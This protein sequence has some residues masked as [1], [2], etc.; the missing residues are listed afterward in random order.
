[1]KSFV[2]GN[3][4]PTEGVY[5]LDVPITPDDFSHIHQQLPS[6]M[7]EEIEAANFNHKHQQQ[8]QQQQ[9]PHNYSN[10]LVPLIVDT[11][12]NFTGFTSDDV[13][14]IG[15]E[16]N[17]YSNNLKDDRNP[18][19]VEQIQM[20]KFQKELD[21]ERR[22]SMKMTIDDRI[23]EYWPNSTMQFIGVGFF[24]IGLIIIILQSIAT[25]Y[26]IGLTY[27][28]AAGIWTGVFCITTSV[29]IL[30]TGYFRSHQTI[31]TLLLWVYCAGFLVF[32][33][34]FILS[35]L[36]I[37]GGIGL[38]SQL[39]NF[40]SVNGEIDPFYFYIPLTIFSILLLFLI[41][42]LLYFIHRHVFSFQKFSEYICN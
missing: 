34:F 15:R 3:D 23:K 18:M 21:R 8:Q 26:R 1:M 9:H 4:E 33:T 13:G 38:T 35:I 22:H 14:K 41:I 24:L 37:T 16:Q 31:V 30:L 36:S 42:S 25:A 39:W 27:Q 40:Q 10:T 2:S 6:K 29:L 28:A 19:F 17:G 32:F 5:N 12:K 11:N 20:S 7:R